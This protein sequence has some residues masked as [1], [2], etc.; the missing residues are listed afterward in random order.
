M[1]LLPRFDDFGGGLCP[2]SYPGGLENTHSTVHNWVGGL[3]TEAETAAQ[4]PIFW[5][6]H[7]YVDALWLQWQRTFSETPL[8]L[9][10]L[11]PGIPGR[12][13]ARETLDVR[14]PRLDYDYIAC[15]RDHPIG[16]LAE[17]QD[18]KMLGLRIPPYVTAIRFIARGIT[19]HGKPPAA[20]TLT[21]VD[22][23]RATLSLFGLGHH[24]DLHGDPH[25]PSTGESGAA[26]W[27]FLKGDVTRARDLPLRLG[28]EW[29]D[30]PGGPAAGGHV[31]V[32]SVTV[33]M[34][35]ALV[36]RS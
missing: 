12:W 29:A 5:F 22:G 24:Q 18:P 27:L 23:M 15:E 10:D 3:M 33:Q 36:A 6:H 35:D 17:H 25:H 11:L 7:A 20:L 28:L 16:E 4:D 32:R 19:V 14:S 31:Q 2:T 13:T 30:P 9:D 21:H 8:R 34:V 1:L 26:G